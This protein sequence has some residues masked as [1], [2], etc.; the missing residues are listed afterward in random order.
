ML[1]AAG[2]ARVGHV[3]LA[4]CAVGVVARV[5]WH[6]DQCGTAATA[7]GVPGLLRDMPTGG[8]R[9]APNVSDVSDVA[10]HDEESPE[11]EGS[12]SGRRPTGRAVFWSLLVLAVL[13]VVIWASTST[14]DRPSFGSDTSSQDDPATDGSPSDGSPSDG[15][16]SDGS[17]PPQDPRSSTAVFSEAVDPL[18][19]AGCSEPGPA[20][21]GEL[22]D[23]GQVV[24]LAYFEPAGGG[25]SD[26]DTTGDSPAPLVVLVGEPTMPAAQLAEDSGILDVADDSFRV[27]VTG[28]DVDPV[29]TGTG[30]AQL[31]G[32]LVNSECIDLSRVNVVGFGGGATVAASLVCRVPELV[33]GVALVA[34]VADPD[35]EVDP[36]VAV[37]I[38]AA[39]DDPTVDS[40]TALLEVGSA[41]ADAVGAE[42]D[43]V[44]GLDEDTLVRSWS[45]PEGLTVRTLSNA[46]GGHA[47]TLETSLEVG[48]FVRE[49][50]RGL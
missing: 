4:P 7:P 38:V 27:G 35:C 41:W 21:G 19:S 45:G 36:A 13:A 39:D 9:C 29:R 34:G 17:R 31:L 23:D 20:P 24:G 48:P 10:P 1:A 37:R 11:P 28:S 25:A 47:W 32:E 40:G 5:V 42:E 50:A 26:S 18:A 3:P 2:A 46:T 44:D 33:S 30:L 12:D 16:A 8:G 14:G 43:T 49:N 6:G 15:S 22:L